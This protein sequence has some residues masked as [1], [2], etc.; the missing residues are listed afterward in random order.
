MKED[1]IEWIVQ[2]GEGS[3]VAYQKLYTHYSHKVFNTVLSY[4]KNQEDAEE[5]HQDPSLA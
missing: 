2:V 1:E 5:V 4:V 3:E